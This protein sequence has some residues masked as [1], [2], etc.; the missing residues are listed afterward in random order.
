MPGDF[1]LPVKHW[2]FQANPKYFDLASHV[3]TMKLEDVSE[4][5]VYQYASEMS[6]GDKI[7][8]WQSGRQGGI[9][10][11]G[12]LIGL[13]HRKETLADWQ[14]AAGRQDPGSVVKF[15]ITHHLRVHLRRSDLKADPRLAQLS[16]LRMASGTN[17]KVRPQEWEAFEDLAERSSAAADEQSQ[18]PEQQANHLR[19]NP[20]W[21]RDE[22]I[23]VLD[24]YLRSG[25]IQL[26]TKHPEVIALSKL[27]NDLPIHPPERRDGT[28]R[29]VNGVNKKMGNIWFLDPKRP[30]GLPGGG[31]GDR[32]VWDEF[33]HRPEHL[34]ELATAIRTGVAELSTSVEDIDEEGFPEGKLIE[35][36]HKRRERNRKLV[37][38]KLLQVQ[39]LQGHLEC[40]V[41]GFDF[42]ATYGPRGEGFAECHHRLP[43]SEVG[44]RVALLTDL[45][46]VCA[47]CHRMIHRIRPY[48]S[49]EGLQA[50]L[51]DRARS[52]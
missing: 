38:Q 2:I 23:L 44:E 29:N 39:L 42:R 49:I 1:P 31:R 35:R 46:V 10:A 48:L 43:L 22:L 13:P 32:E 30:G 50:L 3:Q 14:K 27:L 11:F 51:S 4:W 47:N 18:A 25:R 52:R 34:H 16:I 19:Q 24:L 17:F 36:L 33:A 12:E 20:P 9:Y 45:A 40:E 15:R 28:F 7:A 6:P 5:A 26:G 41:C 21:A 37:K 8:L